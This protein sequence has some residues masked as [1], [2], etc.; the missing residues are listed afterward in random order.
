M[1]I[2]QDL[3]FCLFPSYHKLAILCGPIFF[4]AEHFLMRW[5]VVRSSLSEGEKC[6]SYSPSQPWAG[7]VWALT[8]THPGTVNCFNNRTVFPPQKWN[9]LQPTD[10]P[11]VYRVSTSSH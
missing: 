8:Q 5:S 11:R 7:P 1:R 3:V 4:R 10:V 9:H 2:Q 6:F